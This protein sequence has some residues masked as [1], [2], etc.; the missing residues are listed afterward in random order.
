M[1]IAAGEEEDFPPDD[2]KAGAAGRK[3]SMKSGHSATLAGTRDTLTARVFIADV[4]SRIPT[5]IN[6][7]PKV[8]SDGFTTYRNEHNLFDVDYATLVK[9]YG[10]DPQAERRHSPPVCIGTKRHTILGSPIR[11]T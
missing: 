9:V 3:G 6:E 10:E 5:R 4:K 8:T 7:R 1:R 11:R 2:G